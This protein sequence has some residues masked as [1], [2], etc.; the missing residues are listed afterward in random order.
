M[1]ADAVI[2]HANKLLATL[3]DIH[4]DGPRTGINAV[5][6]QL[7]YHGSRTLDDFTG[8]NLVYQLGGK[9]LDGH[10]ATATCS[11]CAAHDNASGDHRTV[12][13]RTDSRA[14]AGASCLAKAVF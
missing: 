10:R 4:L 12:A 14:L 8:G 1:Y 2:A 6:Q 3:L 5:F 13:G 7:L 11:E 9:N